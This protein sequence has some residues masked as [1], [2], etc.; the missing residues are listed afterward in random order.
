MRVFPLTSMSGQLPELERVRVE[1]AWHPPK[2][3]WLE[4]S[5]TETK[6]SLSAL[7]SAD[8]LRWVIHSRD[9]VAQFPRLS[10]TGVKSPAYHT[11][12]V[13]AKNSWSQSWDSMCHDWTHLTFDA[14]DVMLGA[15]HGTQ[16]T[17]LAHSTMQ[18]IYPCVSGG[19]RQGG[20]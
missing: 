10:Y 12:S 17:A 8:D 3:L 18:P 20:D 5:L 15:A 14:T 2:V 11:V 16:P 7:N 1:M 13:T 19:V 9:I 4:P 6:T